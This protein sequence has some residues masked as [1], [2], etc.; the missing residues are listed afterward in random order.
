MSR[1]VSWIRS[2]SYQGHNLCR[3]CRSVG[4]KLGLILWTCCL[5]VMSR[6]VSWIRSMSYQGHNLCRLCRSVGKKLGLILWT[7]CLNVMSRNILWIRSMSY[8]GHNL[9]RSVAV[10]TSSWNFLAQ[11]ELWRFRAELG[12]FNFGAET[13]LTIQTKCMWKNSDF[14]PLSRIII[15]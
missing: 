8:Q 13:Q 3:L 10:M 6:N 14:V 4:K 7:C 15:R 5:N 11:V 1:N 12:H 2:M 9:C